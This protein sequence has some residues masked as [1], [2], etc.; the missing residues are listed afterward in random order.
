MAFLCQIAR[1]VAEMISG[2]TILLISPFEGCPLSQGSIVRT[3]YLAKFLSEHN[4]VSFAC[5]GGSCQPTEL[6]VNRILLNSPARY[7]QLFS[8]RFLIALVKLIWQ[9]RVDTIVAAHLWAGLHGILLKLITG[10]YLVFDSH[11]V[12]YLRFRRLNS[13]I[14]PFVG[15]LEL[16]VCHVAD[17]ILVVSEIDRDC[18]IRSLHVSP[19]KVQIVVNGAMVKDLLNYSTDETVVRRTIGVSSDEPIILFFGSLNYRPNAQAVDVLLHEIVPRLD[20]R[21][22]WKLVIAGIIPD[23]YVFREKFLLAERVVFAGFVDDIAALIKSSH[24]VVVP[25]TA[26]SGTRFKIIES[27]ACGRRVISTEIGAEG[28]SRDMFGESLLI[29]DEWDGFA[30]QILTTLKQ[31]REIIP[32]DRFIARY[33]WRSIVAGIHLITN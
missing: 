28:L 18:M 27:V 11:N 4:N 5:R 21:A 24:L 25:L 20:C 16:I 33:D 6:G 13:R 26:G 1:V 17:Q 30:Q 31:P 10:K 2:K 29:C 12:E 8:L 19:S 15:L 7:A 22:S 14:W 9:E 32:D 23:T 3:H